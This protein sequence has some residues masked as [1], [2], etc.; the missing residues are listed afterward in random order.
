MFTNTNKSTNTNTNKSTN[1]NTIGALWGEP[2]VRQPAQT[3][4]VAGAIEFWL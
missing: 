2:A 4:H 1:T 3:F